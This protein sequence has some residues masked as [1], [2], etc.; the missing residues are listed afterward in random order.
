[1][2]ESLLIGLFTNGHILVEGVPGVAKTTTIKTLA[3]ILDLEFKR[4]QFTPDLLP[5]DIIGSEI[6]NPKSGDFKIKRGR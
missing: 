3:R 5:S 4:V 6:Y 1:M 2:L